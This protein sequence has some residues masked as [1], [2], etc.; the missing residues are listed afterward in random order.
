MEPTT[1]F[2]FFNRTDATR[3]AGSPRI[4]VGPGFDSQGSV[5]FFNKYCFPN[6]Y[7]IHWV[8]LGKWFGHQLQHPKFLREWKNLQLTPFLQFPAAKNLQGL[9]VS[10][11]CAAQFLSL[12]CF[13]SMASFWGRHCW[14]GG[15]GKMIHFCSFPSQNTCSDAGHLPCL[16][17]WTNTTCVWNCLFLMILSYI[18]DV[19][20]VTP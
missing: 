15:S 4:G 17:S 3:V 11:H 12:C 19:T 10:A 13:M 2:S 18:L 20:I 1:S 7:W 9:T 16:P 6:L 14:H 5:T 8:I